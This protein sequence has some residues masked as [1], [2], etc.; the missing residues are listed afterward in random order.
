VAPLARAAVAI[1]ADAIMVDVHPT[2]DT[3]QVDGEQALL[4]KE[5][6]ELMVSVREIARVVGFRE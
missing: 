4:P 2:P 3:A 5:F 6:A 1:G